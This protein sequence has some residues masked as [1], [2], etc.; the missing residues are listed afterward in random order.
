VVGVNQFDQH[1]VRT[2][3]HPRR[4][5]GLHSRP[6]S[7]TAHRRRSHECGPRAAT[8]PEHPD[9]TPVQCACS[10]HSRGSPPLHGRRVV[11]A[12][13]VDDDLRRGL[14]ACGGMTPAGLHVSVALCA[15]AVLAHSSM[16]ATDS[17]R[18]TFTAPCFSVIIFL[19]LSFEPR[20]TYL[21]TQKNVA[22]NLLDDGVGTEPPTN[23]IVQ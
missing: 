23:T 18:A 13:E 14:R 17:T 3:R 7:A 21:I 5:S 6:P 15:R 1:F 12:A 4:M 2:G 22:R 10:P 8:R 19:L 20:S 9:R 16:A 11:R